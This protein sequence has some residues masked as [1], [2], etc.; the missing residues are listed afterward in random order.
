MKII[1]ALLFVLFTSSQAFPCVQAIE[2][3]TINVG[4][5]VGGTWGRVFFAD[6]S[7][8]SH[9]QQEVEIME[10]LQSFL[11]QRIPLDLLVNEEETKMED[12]DRA[13]F[14]WSDSEGKTVD[15]PLDATHVTSR[16]CE[17]KNVQ[18]SDDLQTFIITQGTP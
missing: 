11:D 12:P 13:T 3:T 9:K 2:Q 17:I 8:K 16:R 5:N 10:R 1:L 18:W 4:I 14:F 6:L 15:N 7:T